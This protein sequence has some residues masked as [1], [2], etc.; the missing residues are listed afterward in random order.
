MTR[1]FAVKAIAFVALACFAVPQAYA[2]GNEDGKPGHRK[3]TDRRDNDR[4]GKKKAALKKKG[5]QRQGPGAK[6]S[7][8][9]RAQLFRALRSQRGR[10]A[11]QS[12][13]AMR[14]AMMRRFMMQRGRGMQQGRGPQFGRPGA[15]RPGL[16]QKHRQ[17]K[18]QGKKHMEQGKARKHRGRMI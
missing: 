5:P 12:H 13:P 6:L 4:R 16:A 11:L 18:G 9:R 14:R 10:S 17:H 3:K 8:E 1:L 7:P 15:R 2:G